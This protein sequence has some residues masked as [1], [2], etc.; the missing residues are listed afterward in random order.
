MKTPIFDFVKKYND[1][2]SI[3]LHMPGHKGISKLG[4]EALDIT[5][6][7][8]A[9]VLYQS[10][11]IIKESQDNASEIFDTA[12]TLYSTEGSSLCIRAMLFLIKQYAIYRN[13]KPLI[14]AGRNAHK[15]FVTASALLG[16]DVS[17]L[18]SSH[19]DFLSCDID[20]CC[21]EKKL[22]K[23]KPT[24]LY[25]TSPD[26]LGNISDI[27]SISKL[28]KKYDVL[29]LVD[30]AHGSYLKFLEKSLHPI[31][32]G[33]DMCCDSAHKTLPV[34]TGGAYLHISE[35]APLLLKENADNAMSIFA[36]TSPSYLI[37]QSLDLFNKSAANGFKDKIS[38][39]S[40]RVKEVKEALANKGFE[41]VGDEPLKITIS[42]K[43]YGYMGY[44]LASLL[45]KENIVVEYSD[46]DFLVLMFSADTKKTD[47][48]MLFEVLDSVKKLKS[49]SSKPP[50]LNP[51]KEKIKPLKAITMQ[52]EYVK[53]SDAVGRILSSPCVSCPPA[54]CVAVCGE[55]LDKTAVDMFLYY[56][57]E[58]VLV[59]KKKPS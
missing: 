9:D 28:C 40:N 1:K 38:H 18:Y 51:L 24:A 17:W 15:T 8:G 39:I 25:L 47:T 5:E 37:L 23:K 56:G 14:L 4:S 7:S 10:N 45:E 32:S 58:E 3:R 16:I 22:R 42:T 59:I 53:T 2:N 27:Q 21:L 31:D 55:K 30:N 20:L 29:L 46:C 41:L 43:N 50:K 13:K 6:V 34:L 11:G 52:S 54:V 48:D 44:D 36:S 49:I 33:A 19:D 26:Y 57:I 12:K 35:N